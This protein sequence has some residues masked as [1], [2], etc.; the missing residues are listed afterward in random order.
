KWEEVIVDEEGDKTSAFFS[1]SK[2]Q[3]RNKLCG[4]KNGGFL[5][6]SKGNVRTMGIICQC[7]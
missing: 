1:L 7:A 2:P 4:L 6:L 3:L 5:F